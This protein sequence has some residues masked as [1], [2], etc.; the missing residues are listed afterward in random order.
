MRLCRFD[1]KG[2]AAAGFFLDDQVVSLNVAAEAA[3]EALEQTD[4]L[5]SFLPHGSQHD[6]AQRLAEW[7]VINESAVSDLAIKLFV[8]IVLKNTSSIYFHIYSSFIKLTEKW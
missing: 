6:V 1:Q 5:L 3:G 8:T 7:L 2:E 4:D